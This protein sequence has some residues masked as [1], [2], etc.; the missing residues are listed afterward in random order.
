GAVDSANAINFATNARYLPGDFFGGFTA[1]RSGSFGGLTASVVLTNRL[2]PCRLTAATDGQIPSNCSN[3]FGNRLDLSYDFHNGNGDNG[4]V[5]GVTNYR[6]QTR[7]QSFTY[8]DLN[9]LASAQTAASDCSTAALNGSR[10]W[11]YGYTY[12]SWGNLLQ[13]QVTKCAGNGL[14]VTADVNNRIHTLA[15]PDFSYDPIGNM[16]SDTLHQYAYNADNMVVS[17]DGAA[18]RYTYDAVG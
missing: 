8:D 3:Q 5:Y 4:N 15:A 14:S 9:R 11:G 16:T 6:D 2:Q 1:G 10:R 12:D 18:A 13:K 17:V 7:N